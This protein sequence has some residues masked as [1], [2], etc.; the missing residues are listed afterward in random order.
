MKKV[1]DECMSN[2]DKIMSDLKCHNNL[3]TNQMAE[4]TR[5]TEEYRLKL[6]E[7]ESRLKE[8]S[9]IVAEKDA[10]ISEVN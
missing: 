6:R 3:M 2:K 10:S 1:F 8:L 7:S 4:E 5:K 9:E